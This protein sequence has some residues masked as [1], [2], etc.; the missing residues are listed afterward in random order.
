MFKLGY[1]KKR[2]KDFEFHARQ[3]EILE[4][5]DAH[6]IIH[7]CTWFTNSLNFCNQGNSVC[8]RHRAICGSLKSWLDLSSLHVSACCERPFFFGP[9]SASCFDKSNLWNL[10]ERS[11]QPNYQKDIIWRMTITRHLM[12]W[13]SLQCVGRVIRKLSGMRGF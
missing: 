2:A 8:R 12:N 7:M 10:F 6:L 9:V 5:Y 11:L 4:R 1:N 13:A 3:H